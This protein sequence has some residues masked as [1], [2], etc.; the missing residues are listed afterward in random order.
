MNREQRRSVQ[1]KTGLSADQIKTVEK[2][3]Q[4]TPLKAETIPEGAHVKLK[5]DRLFGMKDF[6]SM[7]TK[8]RKF[9][10]EHQDTV[11]TVEYDPK[12]GDTPSLVQFVEDPN[13]IKFLWH[14][15]DL[16]VVT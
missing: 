1:K 7:Q 2:V 13:E 14:I 10:Q 11:F 6:A 16:E 9:V 15:S 12:F 8:W 4:G 3:M 5:T